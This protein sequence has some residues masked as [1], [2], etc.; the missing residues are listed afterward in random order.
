MTFLPL[1]L[2]ILPSQRVEGLDD[3]CILRNHRTE[4]VDQSQERLQLGPGTRRL[5]RTDLLGYFWVW[6]DAVRADKVAQ[7]LDL[8]G[9]EN[10]FRLIDGHA[11]FL[12][13]SEHGTQASRKEI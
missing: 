13:S 7:E 8:R 9:V 4:E 2:F 6:K 1:E 10:G 12:E 5:K 11:F 3:L